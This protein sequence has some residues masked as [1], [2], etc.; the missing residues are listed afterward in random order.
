MAPAVDRKARHDEAD[1]NGVTA[2]HYARNEG[3][4]KS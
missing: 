1:N 4:V 2:L 3:H